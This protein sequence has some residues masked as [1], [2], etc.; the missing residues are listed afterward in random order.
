MCLLMQLHTS[1][2][3]LPCSCKVLWQLLQQVQMQLQLLHQTSSS[4]N[5]NS[6]QY[7]DNSHPNSL[8]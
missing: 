6:H 1:L 5:N 2:Q 8:L 7:L 3:L 4:N